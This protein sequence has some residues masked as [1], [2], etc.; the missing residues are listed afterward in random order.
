RL[1]IATMLASPQFLYRSELGQSIG[2]GRYRLDDYEIAS[3]LSYLLWGSMPD[4]TLLDAAAA[5][6][7]RSSD[8]RLA[9]VERMLQDARAR[10]RFADFA[11]Q[12][13]GTSYLLGA[14]KDPDI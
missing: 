4:D 6:T 13:L 8:G 5:G 9:Q 11:S 2:N 1:A 14:F 10:E 3:S 7:L 12:W